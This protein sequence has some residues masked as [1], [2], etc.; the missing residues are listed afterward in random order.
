[1]N[2]E[3][4]IEDVVNHLLTQVDPQVLALMASEGRQTCSDGLLR[5]LVGG[6]NLKDPQASLYVML[7]EAQRA[8]FRDTF[9]SRYHRMILEF[10]ELK[11][12]LLHHQKIPDSEFKAEI[13]NYVAR[14]DS[15]LG[16]SIYQIAANKYVTEAVNEAHAK[17]LFSNFASDPHKMHSLSDKTAMDSLK[18][19][20]TMTSMHCNQRFSEVKTSDKGMVK[21]I[22]SG[23]PFIFEAC[24]IA[25]ILPCH[26]AEARNDF[27]FIY[28]TI[29]LVCGEELPEKT[30]Y[31]AV[32]MKGKYNGINFIGVNFYAAFPQLSE[33]MRISSAV[34]KRRHGEFK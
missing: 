15:A 16:L 3:A 21:L 25:E 12:K 26:K 13:I 18:K 10:I 11:E 31:T 22:G 29:K 4:F 24:H 32:R 17:S 5:G 9:A 28:D 34:Q 7:S 8:K 30:V 19:N 20:V 14:S 33:A 2:R 23:K 6:Q 27:A 1:M